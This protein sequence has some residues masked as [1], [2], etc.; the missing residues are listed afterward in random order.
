M[1]IQNDL[2]IAPNQISPLH[3]IREYTNKKKNTPGGHRKNL[4]RMQYSMLEIEGAAIFRTS[5]LI[6]EG[7]YETCES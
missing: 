4:N 7:S 6:M 2:P 3:W 1:A 5:N